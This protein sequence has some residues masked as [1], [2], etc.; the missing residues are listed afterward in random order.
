MEKVSSMKRVQIM[1]FNMPEIIPN[2]TNKGV[3][4]FKVQEII[5]NLNRK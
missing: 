5:S 2:Y 4:G 3:W 1:G